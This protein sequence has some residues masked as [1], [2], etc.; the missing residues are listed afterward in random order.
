MINKPLY[1]DIHALQSVPPSCINRDDTGSPKTA[2]F[3]GVLRARVSSQAWKKATRDEFA[4][5]L[6]EEEIGQ[7]T[8]H[9]VDLIA[10]Y[11]ARITPEVTTDDAQTMATAA[12]KATGIS[13][14]KQ[15]A[16]GYLLFISPM[17][18]EE[19]ARLAIAARQSDGKIVAKE[20]KSILN[21]RERPTLNAVDIALFGRMVADAPNLNVDATVQVAHALG[22]G[23]AQTEYDYFTAMDD[24]SPEDTAGAGM[25]G[26]VEY[27]SATFYRYATVDIRHLCEN[28]GSSTATLRAIE[29]FCTAFVRSMPT[30][31]Q[32]TFANRTL[33]AAVIMQLR[34]T[35]PVSLANAFERPVYAQGDKSQ[36]RIACERLVE[37]ERFVDEAFG[38]KPQRTYAIIASPDAMAVEQ[39]A[40]EVGSL[41]SV[42]HAISEHVASY[43]A[44]VN[45]EA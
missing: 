23:A 34:D 14:G 26:T 1:L 2:R 41:A 24:R 40:D 3:G 8:V 28:L 13:V 10:E 21:P 16:T 35:Q 29:A 44:M 17:Q 45:G 30:G 5:M 22:V 7:R 33:P 38:V 4:T 36:T 18:A 27:L 31:K 12:L 15:N 43:L 25:I 19:L 37:Q 32:N 6:E 42:T 9:A 39:M 20:A 11:I